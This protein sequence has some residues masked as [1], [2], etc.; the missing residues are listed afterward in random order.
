MTNLCSSCRDLD[1]SSCLSKL[2]NCPNYK[3]Y[4]R[5]YLQFNDLVF[6]GVESV[7]SA[8]LSGDYRVTTDDY[9][10]RNGA[11]YGG[12]Y[13]TGHLL[14]GAQDLGLELTLPF[15][16]L[17]RLQVLDYHDWIVT[18]L[19][20]AGKIWAI[21][22]GGILIWA[23]AIPT[24]PPFD[25]YATSKGTTLKTTM[26]F[27]LPEGIWHKADTHNVFLEPYDLCDFKNQSNCCDRDCTLK[28]PC[29]NGGCMDNS[30]M[31]CC[32]VSECM[33]WCKT[34]WNPYDDGCS[35]P[36]HIIYDCTAGNEFYGSRTWGTELLG[37]ENCLSG[38]FCSNTLTASPV[39]VTLL[40]H[41]LNPV[42][43][44]NDI[45]IRIKGEF[46]GRLVVTTEGKV[47]YYEGEPC[48][49]TCEDELD[50][51]MKLPV[52]LGYSD[53]ELICYKL[54]FVANN[55]TN[56]V[57]VRSEDTGSEGSEM[58]FAYVL[59]DETRY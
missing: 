27:V 34:C 15:V 48:G 45:T 6:S 1:M 56:W 4:P 53:V 43:T 13:T 28:A 9:A 46:D 30:C 57:E 3:A 33:N 47:L 37:D 49:D 8:D 16:G 25:D 41:Y 22:T 24:H 39:Q 20:K 17:T 35:F 12:S 59:V 14:S 51:L 55:G 23:Y 32:G 36:Y 38:E 44:V 40:G 54:F 26:D 42:I 52:E 5:I 31:S 50:N 10:V 18:N 21:D 29:V 11:Y 58:K 2:N 19:S 7:E